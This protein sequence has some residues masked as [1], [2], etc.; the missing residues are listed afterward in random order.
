[1]L[2]C[3][4]LDLDHALL[5]PPPSFDAVVEE[6]GRPTLYMDPVLGRNRT[7][8]VDFVKSGISRGVFVAGKSRVEDVAAFFVANKDERIRMVLD[9]RRSNQRFQPPPSVSLFSA[10]GFS[11]LEVPKDTPLYFAGVDVQ[12]AFYQ[13]KLPA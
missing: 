4:L 9:C 12:N 10:A 3:S 8:Y 7:M 2:Q 6:D 1:M 11:D 13:R 5:Q